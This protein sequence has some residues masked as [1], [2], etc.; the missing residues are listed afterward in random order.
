MEENVK[1]LIYSWQE[2]AN[3]KRLLRWSWTSR[4]LVTP[5]EMKELHPKL[6]EEEKNELGETS[7]SPFKQ[8]VPEIPALVPILIEIGNISS[9]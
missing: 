8:M 4:G 6:N 5:D 9:I 3:Y 2:M 7:P 1:A